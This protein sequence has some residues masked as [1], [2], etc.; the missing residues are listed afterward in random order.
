MVKLRTRTLTDLRRGTS[1][2]GCRAAV[3]LIAQPGAVKVR[4]KAGRK[5]ISEPVIFKITDEKG[6]K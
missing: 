4:R 5:P 3:D 6:L 1:L 2:H